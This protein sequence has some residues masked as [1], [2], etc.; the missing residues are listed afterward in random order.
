MPDPAP[1]AL[2]ADP[3]HDRAPP[4]LAS[5]PALA[6]LVWEYLRAHP[7]PGPVRGLRA[8]YGHTELGLRRSLGLLREGG[9]VVVETVQAGG[10]RGRNSHRVLTPDEAE[11]RATLPFKQAKD[12]L[13][14]A[15]RHALDTENRQLLH[16]RQTLE[17]IIRAGSQAGAAKQLRITP[18]AVARR[19]QRG[20]A[21]LD[22][23]TVSRRLVVTL[24]A[25]ESRVGRPQG[26][27]NSN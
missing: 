4:A 24:R 25:L 16:Y 7:G 23:G 26:S 8:R 12:R 13:E 1:A 21:L 19:L 14:R 3:W 6:Q 15:G 11:V 18:S 20:R 22:G 27:P 5:Y 17:A 10:G 9:L 2:D